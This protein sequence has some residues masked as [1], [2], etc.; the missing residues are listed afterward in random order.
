[1]EVRLGVCVS[2]FMFVLV[3]GCRRVEE[4][5]V[6]GESL[7]REKKRGLDRRKVVGEALEWRRYSSKKRCSSGEKPE[8]HR[9]FSGLIRPAKAHEKNA[10]SGLLEAN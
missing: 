4:F 9:R 2:A 8:S 6:K 1:M 10:R 3:V 7:E 5:G